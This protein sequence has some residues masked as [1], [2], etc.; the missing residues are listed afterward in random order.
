MRALEG[1]P[2][3]DARRAIAMSLLMCAPDSRFDL[4]IFSGNHALTGN[5]VLM[6]I[7]EHTCLHE[8]VEPACAFR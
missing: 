5:E 8:V 4:R 1:S 7:N 2:M 6:S 3:A